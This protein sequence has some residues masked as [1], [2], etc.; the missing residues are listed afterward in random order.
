MSDSFY[1]RLRFVVL[2]CFLSTAS[3]SLLVVDCVQ[4]L[5]ADG[6]NGD[7]QNGDGQNGDGQNGDGQ[8]GD[9]QNGDGQ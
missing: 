9:G 2:S 6:Q 3:P 8:N 1:P 5:A 7:G 4:A